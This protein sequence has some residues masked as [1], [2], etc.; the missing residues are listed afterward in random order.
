[1]KL[2]GSVT[3]C[4]ALTSCSGGRPDAV[5]LTAAT[6]VVPLAQ[7]VQA[8]GDPFVASELVLPA[9]AEPHDAALDAD[10]I[11][12]LERA[13]V[14]F[15]IGGGFQPSVEDAVRTHPR[16]IDVL[17]AV[18]PSS[19]DPHLWLDPVAMRDAA[20]VIARALDDAHPGP[21]SFD[22][23]VQGATR[24]FDALHREFRTAL[25]SCERRVLITSHEAFGHLAARYDLEQHG[26]TGVSPGS[27]PDPKRLA[28]LIDLVRSTGT[29]TV[30]AEANEPDDVAGTL[31][32]ESGV[33][34]AVLDPIERIPEGSTYE[35]RMR[36]NLEVLVE[37]LGCAG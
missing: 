16:A 2:I 18:A 36:A 30:F 24:R 22:V 19:N 35:K 29:T 7:L 32:R 12:A 4:L 10:Q 34:V 37:A 1:M 13:D 6:T 20:G 9:G 25:A 15:F 11:D 3:L 5:P 8:I 28:G 23:G 17:A 33:R 26:I 14:V 31:A 21:A 27:Q